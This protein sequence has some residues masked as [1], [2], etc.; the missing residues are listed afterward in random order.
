MARPKANEPRVAMKVPVSFRDMAQ[1]EAKALGMIATVYLEGK[2]IVEK[3]IGGSRQ[4][5]TPTTA[6]SGGD[7]VVSS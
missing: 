6:T 3:E 7:Q 1:R 5:N 4:A 2:R